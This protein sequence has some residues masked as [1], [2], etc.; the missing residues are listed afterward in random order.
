M[1]GPRAACRRRSAAP[2]PQPAQ[3]CER[4]RTIGAGQQHLRAA[5]QPARTTVLPGGPH[6]DARPARRAAATALNAAHVLAIKAAWPSTTPISSA[7]CCPVL[8]NAADRPL[9]ASDSSISARCAP[10]AAEPAAASRPRLSAST[11]AQPIL[12][13]ER[14]LSR[15]FSRNSVG[16]APGAPLGR[17]PSSAVRQQCVQ[18]RH[19]ASARGGGGD[20]MPGHAVLHASQPRLDPPSPLASR[21]LRL[22]M[23]VS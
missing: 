17:L 3:R 4:L 5:G 22:A 14:R 8:A 9:A 21:R 23:A 18:P 6:P 1:L 2:P 10:C 19:K 11:A 20:R 16:P 13:G 15:H 7:F 12:Y